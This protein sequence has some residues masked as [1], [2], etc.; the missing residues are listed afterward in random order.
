VVVGVAA[1]VFP[2]IYFVSDVVESF[3]GD[4]TVERLTLTYLGE[5]AIPLFVLGLYGMQRPTIGRIGLLGAVLYAYSFVFFTSTVVFALFGDSRDWSA[6]TETFRAWLT[7]HGTLMVL[8][9]LTFGR[10][11]WQARVLPAWTGPYL[12][13][14]VMLV[15]AASGLPT[16][17]RTGA[18]AR[19]TP[20]F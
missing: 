8:G 15:A 6:V 7:V 3:Q 14:G 11:V 20:S 4:F 18:A 9:G 5:A 1:V 2:L 19:G 10:A 13:V 16:L 12:A 17:V